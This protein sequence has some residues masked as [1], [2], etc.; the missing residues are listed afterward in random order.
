MTTVSILVS[1]CAAGAPDAA[2]FSREGA[3]EVIP[4]GGTAGGSAAEALS[5]ASGDVVVFVAP[6]DRLRAGAVSRLTAALDSTAFTY[7]DEIRGGERLW[8]PGWSPH[9]LLSFG[10]VGHPWAVRKRTAIDAGGLRDSA[11]P[12]AELDLQLRLAESGATAD[13]VADVLSER[14]DDPPLEPE[15]QRRVVVEACERRRIPANVTIGP[16]SGLVRVE[17]AKFDESLTVIIPTRDRL[18]LLRRAIEGLE[19]GTEWSDLEILIVDNDSKEAETK[20]YL[21]ASP[22]RVIPFEGAF[23]FAAIHNAVVPQARGRLVL[24]LNNDTEMID[25]AWLRKMVAQA[26]FPHVGAVGAWLLYPDRRVQH[27]G[28][29]LRADHPV[30]LLRGAREEDFRHRYFGIVPC[31]VTAV[32]GACMLIRKDLF[33]EV[34]GFDRRFRVG[35]NDIDLCLRLRRLGYATVIEPA[36]RLVHHESASRE[37]VLPLG[38]TVLFR[39]RWNH[40]YPHGDPHYHPALDHHRADFSA[41]PFDRVDL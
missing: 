4:F 20:R 24:F 32:T 38:E 3:A 22:H 14:D 36:A 19:R 27:A 8:K 17:P 10:F 7:G 25:A 29:I 18:D 39:A 6:G 31:D 26:A 16:A 9:L 33:L 13:R 11:G 12:A 15:A 37:I 5:R 30:H 28:V 35:F 23:D 1:G 41:L 21:A 40:H 34:G 2:A